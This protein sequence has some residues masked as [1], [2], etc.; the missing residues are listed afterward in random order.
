MMISVQGSTMDSGGSDGR[1]LYPSVVESG[2]MVY[3]PWDQFRAMY[4]TYGLPLPPTL[5]GLRL[6]TQNSSDS[7]D[8]LECTSNQEKG[9]ESS[10]P[11]PPGTKDEE[12]ESS[13]SKGGETSQEESYSA[14][15][16]IEIDS[17]DTSGSPSL[18]T[19]GPPE[20]PAPTLSADYG[21]NDSGSSHSPASSPEGNGISWM[22]HPSFMSATP[23][24]EV[25]T[26]SPKKRILSAYMQESP[27]DEDQIEV[28][29]DCEAQ[30]MT[31]S[32]KKHKWN[33]SS[34]SSSSNLKSDAQT[35]PSASLPSPEADRASPPSA[36]SWGN[37][38]LKMEVDCEAEDVAVSFKKHK[39]DR[40]SS[41]SSD[42]K[43]KLQIPPSSASL[44]SY[45]ADYCSQ[46]S[47]DSSLASSLPHS[48]L[49]G[50]LLPGMPPLYPSLMM[51]QYTASHAAS[52]ALYSHAQA[53]MFGGCFLRLP[54]MPMPFHAP[55][56]SKSTSLTSPLDLSNDHNGPQKIDTSDSSQSGE[57]PL[58]L[59]TLKQNSEE[60]S[61]SSGTSYSK[62]LGD[63]AHEKVGKDESK[64]A[65]TE[66]I[67][68][69]E[70]FMQHNK[71]LMEL[72]WRSSASGHM[73]GYS[74][75]LSIYQ[76][77]CEY[78]EKE[79]YRI[80]MRNLSKGKTED[81]NPMFDA[82]RAKLISEIKKEIAMLGGRD[83]KSDF[84]R[85]GAPMMP[86]YMFQPFPSMMNS[87]AHG[88][89]PAPSRITSSS[90][91]PNPLTPMSLQDSSDS[92]GI[93]FSGRRK[94]L[95][96][97]AIS[98]LST[99]Y[100]QNADHPY[101]E[102]EVCMAL[103]QRAGISITQVK[104]WMA[105]KRV[106]SCNT[107][108]Y[109]G[110]IHPKKLQKLMQ[111]QELSRTG[112][113]SPEESPSK[114]KKVRRSKRMLNPT[115]VDIM[116]KWYFE[117]LHY[118]YPSDNEKLQLAT[119]GGITVS[120]VT[121]WFANKRNRSNHTRKLP[122]SVSPMVHGM[123]SRTDMPVF[124]GLPNVPTS[125]TSQMDESSDNQ[126]RLCMSPTSSGDADAIQSSSSQS[127]GEET[128][129]NESS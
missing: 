4:Q 83:V 66:T 76:S 24:N 50:G 121:C 42:V 5:T 1:P 117:H 128:F 26:N 77:K 29:Q 8:H 105:N 65:P 100:E 84:G 45:G 48:S 123:Q 108:S 38:S 20:Q 23:P 15:L 62:L 35:T 34:S 88:T 54:G 102:G 98:V 37:A 112:I 12:S 53:Q 22:P 114:A 21:I 30:D 116:N 73:S 94:F 39:W 109:N 44:L 13:S 31:A 59:T 64:D 75:L 11:A 79:R 115:A 41:P 47:S 91:L 18:G 129:N 87:P 36:D 2:E 33:Y 69:E 14:S 55:T 70:L 110:S 93:E 113:S 28:S 63:I 58:N 96:D 85:Y 97:T 119:Q 120:Q 74:R 32:F 122:S 52:M 95:S 68:H 82:E 104:K 125:G 61:S 78:I 107:L 106:R 124:P 6:D 7:K 101:P 81:F 3:N 80:A 16:K 17:P 9:S 71:L 126:D 27:P 25:Y 111:L 92:D 127:N 99:W 51:P 118:P 103:A 56:S 89:Y 72:T 57:E 40:S 49:Y 43:S 90:S 60:A 10:S 19:P 86:A 67:S 46:S